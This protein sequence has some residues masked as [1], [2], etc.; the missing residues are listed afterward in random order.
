MDPNANIVQS[1]SEAERR[2]VSHGKSATKGGLK[3]K[4]TPS[5]THGGHRAARKG[6]TCNDTIRYKGGEVS[7]SAGLGPFRVTMPHGRIRHIE[8]DPAKRPLGL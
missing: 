7:N 6:W 5:N 4:R 3:T 2:A 1:M 8:T